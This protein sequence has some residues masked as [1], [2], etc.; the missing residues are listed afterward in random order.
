MCYFV[1]TSVLNYRFFSYF[2]KMK[3]LFEWLGTSLPLFNWISYP[4][5]HYSI[6]VMSQRY[7][8]TCLVIGFLH[9][10]VVLFQT[11]IRQCSVANGTLISVLPTVSYTYYH[12]IQMQILIYGETTIAN[13]S[14]TKYSSFILELLP[15]SRGIVTIAQCCQL[16]FLKWLCRLAKLFETI[17]VIFRNGWEFCISCFYS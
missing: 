3:W 12:W 1:L 14:T 2:A 16:Q 17:E 10:T 8:V 5:H 15:R 6:H 9:N 11:D 7:G 13:T 4:F